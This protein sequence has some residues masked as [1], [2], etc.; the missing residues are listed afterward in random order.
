ML[1]RELE[2]AIEGDAECAPD[3]IEAKIGTVLS[4]QAASLVRHILYD[5]DR[6]QAQ[7]AQLTIVCQW[8]QRQGNGA[9]VSALLKAL[10][11][12]TARHVRLRAAEFLRQVGVVSDTVIRF[13]LDVQ[14][15]ERAAE[16]PGQVRVKEA[17]VSALLEA[18]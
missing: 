12:W 17:V 6:R 3:G 13:E 5:A 18:D 15:W 11:G 1:A 14:W 8:S 4:A 10:N 16:S 2:L 7:K 9:V